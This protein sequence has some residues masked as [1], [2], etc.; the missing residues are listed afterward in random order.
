MASALLLAML[1]Q[2]PAVAKV[3]RAADEAYA[4]R[5]EAGQAA[6]ARTAYRKALALDEASV[7]AYVGLAKTC[8]WTG[9][10]EADSEKAATA[11]R[12][13][14]DACKIAV[15]VNAESLDAHFWLA[16]LYGLYG[17]TKGIL[18]SLDLLDPMRAELDWVLKKDEAFEDAGAHRVYG[19]LY[20]KLPGV[21][22]GDNHKAEKHLR[23]AIELA[24]KNLLNYHYLAEVLVAQGRRDEAKEAL[25]TMIA[26]PDDPRW[27][28]E[29][30]EQRADGKKLLEKLE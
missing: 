30:R 22:G 19:R 25:R 4:K 11:F 24:P 28:P 8:F 6:A 17:Q 18:Q 14:I 2:D 12:E 21:K 23:R 29:S 13:G 15:S 26:Q 20:H 3:L 9:T 10:H 27:K 7:P 5:D 16:V 1:L